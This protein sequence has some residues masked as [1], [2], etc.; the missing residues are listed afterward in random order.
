MSAMTLCGPSAIV[1][2]DIDLAGHAIDDQRVVG[3]DVVVAVLPVQI[4]DAF[5]RVLGGGRQERIAGDE[6]QLRQ[7]SVVGGEDRVART[8]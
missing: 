5:E 7:T 6:R 2:V 1:N 3:A 8:R 4:A